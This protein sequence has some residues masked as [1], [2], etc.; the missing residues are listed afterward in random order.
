M[1]KMYLLILAFLLN[2]FNSLLAQTS[3]EQFFAVQNA[4]RGG[5][6]ITLGFTAN[7]SFIRF[8]KFEKQDYLNLSI[9]NEED[10]M[11][12]YGL[13][14]DFDY[15]EVPEANGNVAFEKMSFNWEFHDD[16]EN[17]DSVWPGELI[18]Y[19][20]ANADV[21]TLKL[22]DLNGE[23]LRIEGYV[24]GTQNFGKED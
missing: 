21:Y 16:Y 20:K 7:K 12:L 10:T 9:E 5:E 8:Y 22:I 3:F 1:N 13:L 23:L 4:Q 11:A 6:N 2:P 18:I 24:K 19:H 17:T 15:E 14:T